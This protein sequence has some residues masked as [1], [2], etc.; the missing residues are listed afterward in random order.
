M[1]KN[2]EINKLDNMNEQHRTKC[3]EFVTQSAYELE[4]SRVV[5]WLRLP[6]NIVVIPRIRPPGDWFTVSSRNF[7]EAVFKGFNYCL[8][9]KMAINYQKPGWMSA[10]FNHMKPTDTSER[11]LQSYL[12]ILKAIHMVSN[13]TVNSVAYR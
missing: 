13:Q 10:P 3:L 9:T 1:T 2:C 4:S 5:K 6:K 12:W 8:F 11:Q 7:Y